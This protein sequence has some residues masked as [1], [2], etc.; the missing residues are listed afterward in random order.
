MDK[1]T[2]IRQLIHQGEIDIVIEKV[3]NINTGVYLYNLLQYL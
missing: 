2:E 3:N 1:R